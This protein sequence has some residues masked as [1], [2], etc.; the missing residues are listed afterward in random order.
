M[1]VK[2]TPAYVSEHIN[3]DNVKSIFNR[4]N[5][6]DVTDDLTFADLLGHPLAKI[7]SLFPK[8]SSA[9]ES[10]SKTQLQIVAGDDDSYVRVC[11]AFTNVSREVHKVL[12]EEYQ[13]DGSCYIVPT[14]LY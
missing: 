6:L 5:I 12:R 10:L 8:D 9:F 4:D 11:E 13:A 14:C 3:K 1:P 7:K 2:P